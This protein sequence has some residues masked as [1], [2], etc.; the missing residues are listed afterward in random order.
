MYGGSVG[1]IRGLTQDHDLSVVTY[2][3]FRDFEGLPEPL[4]PIEQP[5]G[6]SF[7]EVAIEPTGRDKFSH[8]LDAL[9]F[10]PVGRH[11]HK[12]VEH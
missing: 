5:R 10:A 8:L 7:V 6:V 4:V 3:P 11:R 2:Q 12:A 9:G 1:E